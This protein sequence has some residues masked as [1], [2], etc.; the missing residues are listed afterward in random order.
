ME[1]EDDNLAAQTTGSEPE[2]CEMFSKPRATQ[3]AKKMG[4]K[5]GWSLDKATSDNDGRKWDLTRPQV[6]RRAIE[7]IERTRPKAI[8]MTPP[9]TAK[10]AKQW[11]S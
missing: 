7:P 8:I 3:I 4:M 5:S 10:E 6:Q 1:A 11:N 2:I 9:T